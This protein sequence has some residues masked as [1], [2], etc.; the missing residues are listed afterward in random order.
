[1]DKNSAFGELT[2]KG[3]Q[4]ASNTAQKAVSDVA[5][6]VAGQLGFRNESASNTTQNTQQVQD[7]APAQV[8]SERGSE[9]QPLEDNE[10]TKEMVE[11]FYA[12]SNPA[13]NLTSEQQE[14]LDTKERLVTLRKELHDQIYY[15]PLVNP[16]KVDEERPAERVERQEKQEMQDLQQKD[17]EKPP[18][19]AVQ[20]AQTST[21][22]NR[23]V[24]G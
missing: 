13:Q 3:Q 4:A 9:P 20:R 24:A 19:I 17:A 14:E 11:D 16:K 7:Q 1:M 15:D 8:P 2:E 12:P 22:M 23:G 10:L 6:S 5:S 18:P 21:E